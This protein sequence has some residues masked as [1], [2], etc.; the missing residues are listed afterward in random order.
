MR[1]AAPSKLPSLAPPSLPPLLA[2]TRTQRPSTH[3]TCKHAGPHSA[4]VEQVSAGV[5]HAE[6][7]PATQDSP[8]RHSLLSLHM[9]PVTGIAHVASGGWISATALTDATVIKPA[10]KQLAMNG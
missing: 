4:V 1:S 2:P 6:H 7:R 8:A 9:L 3:S 5:P 10:D